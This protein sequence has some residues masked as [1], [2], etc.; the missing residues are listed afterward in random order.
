MQVSHWRPTQKAVRFQNSLLIT[1]SCSPVSEP[2]PPP[3]PPTPTPT[4]Q[5]ARLTS[6]SF[7]AAQVYV[8]VFLCL[9][10]SKVDWEP[11]LFTN[12]L[13]SRAKKVYENCSVLKKNTSIVVVVV[14]FIRTRPLGFRAQHQNRRVKQKQ[15]NPNKIERE[16][17]KEKERRWF[18]VFWTTLWL[19]ADVSSTWN[20]HKP[21]KTFVC[22]QNL[23]SSEQVSAKSWFVWCV[24]LLWPR[25]LLDQTLGARDFCSSAAS[26]LSFASA[27][28]ARRRQELHSLANTTACCCLKWICLPAS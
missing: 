10:E 18:G 27:T 3:T 1:L 21:P 19:R 28:F 17:E 26:V 9:H 4:S 14:V 5:A 2:P 15:R 16:W 23:S 8:R 13:N 7:E 25:P 6:H 22:A 24:C 20:A 12:N 11:T